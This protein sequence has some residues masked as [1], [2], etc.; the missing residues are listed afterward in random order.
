[1]RAELNKIENNGEFNKSHY[2]KKL[3][4]LINSSKINQE[5]N[6]E[7]KKYLDDLKNPLTAKKT[8]F[9]IKEL[10][11]KVQFQI[12]SLVKYLSFIKLFQ[13]TE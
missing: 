8:E 11:K 7:S 13:K 3:M 6:K 4:K 5:R 10:P 9:I 12:I 2:F 1:M